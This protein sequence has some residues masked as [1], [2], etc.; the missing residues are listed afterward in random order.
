MKKK[1]FRERYRAKNVGQEIKPAKKTT[2]NSKKI[3]K[4]D[5]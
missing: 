1:A 3:A 4:G 5:K 2:K